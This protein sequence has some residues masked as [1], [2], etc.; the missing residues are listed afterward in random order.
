MAAM[1]L[2]TGVE[3]HCRPRCP[4][5]GGTGPQGAA[6]ALLRAPAVIGNGRPGAALRADPGLWGGRPPPD[7]ALQWQRDGADI[8]GA[9]DMGFT[10][11]AAEAATYLR[12]RVT[13]RNDRGSA[14]AVS[15]AIFIPAAGSAAPG[16]PPDPSTDNSGVPDLTTSPD[17]TGPALNLSVAGPGITLDPATG[18]V[19]IAAER[20]R[21]GLDL[22][23]TA[24]G[25]GAA[26]GSFRLRIQAVAAVQSPP[27]LLAAPA[28]VAAAVI[29]D[30]LAV[31]PGRWEGADSLALQWRRDGADIAGATEASY[32]PAE[33]DDR[34]ALSCRVTASNV[35]GETS[36]ETEPMPVAY[37]AP[38]VAG[39]L[40]DLDLVLDGGRQRRGGFG[41]QRLRR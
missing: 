7:L 5:A 13:A 18:T 16:D 14:S 40:A 38:V 31:D 41:L 24:T 9:R 39:A 23:V 21:D 12:L 33:A 35:A 30:P 27:K 32:T 36:A 20:L 15:E 6:P 10:P 22:T 17:F 28:I 2:G 26:A 37:A 8:P 4:A 29:G 19:G 3:A 11:G 25:A 34:T 1:S